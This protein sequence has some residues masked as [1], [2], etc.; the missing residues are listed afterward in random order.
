MI[1][2]VSLVSPGACRRS[3]WILF[4]CDLIVPGVAIEGYDAFCFASLQGMDFNWNI[5]RQSGTELNLPKVRNFAQGWAIS[6]HQV[7]SLDTKELIGDLGSLE[8]AGMLWKFYTLLRGPN[9]TALELNSSLKPILFGLI[10]WI[11]PEHLKLEEFIQSFVFIFS[12][13]QQINDTSFPS[14]HVT[15][16]WSWQGAFPFR[17]AMHSLAITFSGLIPSLRCILSLL[18]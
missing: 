1:G 15:L 10:I 12:K 3:R 4:I 6:S 16:G 11:S 18:L 9:M 7:L 8:G 2:S 13:N 17:W 5:R 14:L